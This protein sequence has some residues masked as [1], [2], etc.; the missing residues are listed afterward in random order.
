M[1][2]LFFKLMLA[3]AGVFAAFLGLDYLNRKSTDR[4]VALYDDDDL[5]EPF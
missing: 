2:K 1:L 3:L 5:D 4:Y